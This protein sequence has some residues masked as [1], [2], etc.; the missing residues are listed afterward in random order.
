[1]DCEANEDRARRVV[2]SKGLATLDDERFFVRC[3]FPIHAEKYDVWNVG[4]WVEVSAD[5]YKHTSDLWDVPEYLGHSLRGTLANAFPVLGL[6]VGSVVEAKAISENE[7]PHIVG[8]DDGKLS[9]LLKRELP[10]DEFERLAVAG[11]YL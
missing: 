5:S 9:D 4:L 2:T 7:L 11:H 3:L 10:T 8:A 1:M 6:A